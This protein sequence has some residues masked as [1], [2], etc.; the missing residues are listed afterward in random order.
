[1]KIMTKIN[2]D[3]IRFNYQKEEEFKQ[4][5]E[6]LQKKYFLIFM[7]WR[8]SLLIFTPIMNFGLKILKRPK[9]PKSPVE[10]RRLYKIYEMINR[11]SDPLNK[12][13]IS[14]L[15]LISCFGVIQVLKNYMSVSV[16]ELFTDKFLSSK[17]QNERHTV[18]TF[19]V[20]DYS[21]LLQSYP[22]SK[23]ISILNDHQPASVPY[24]L[25][26]QN[27]LNRLTFGFISLNPIKFADSNRM[28]NVFEK[29]KKHIFYL[30]YL[31]SNIFDSIPH[32]LEAITPSDPMIFPLLKIFKNS[33][34]IYQFPINRLFK[35]KKSK[36]SQKINPWN[37]LKKYYRK[38]P[39]LHQVTQNTPYTIPFEEFDEADF[40]DF[41]MDPYLDVNID[42][43]TYTDMDLD[44][45]LFLYEKINALDENVTNARNTSASAES[46]N[47]RIVATPEMFPEAT[48]DMVKQS[49]DRTFKSLLKS[50]RINFKK[51]YIK[52]KRMHDP[53]N[54]TE[55]LRKKVNKARN[56]AQIEGKIQKAIKDR[57]T[58]RYQIKFEKEY[59]KLYKE[60]ITDKKNRVINA[61]NSQLKIEKE[62]EKKKKL[63][64]PPIFHFLFKKNW[65]YKQEKQKNIRIP[66]LEVQTIIK[67]QFDKDF[68]HQNLFLYR[69]IFKY[70]KRHYYN[71]IIRPRLCS[72]YIYP[73]IKKRRGRVRIATKVKNIRSD[74]PRGYRQKV[75][76]RLLKTF[77]YTESE[78]NL[79]CLL[80]NIQESGKLTYPKK[81]KRFQTYKDSKISFVV[82]IGH[83]TRFF[84]AN[85]FN[86]KYRS[87][88]KSYEDLNPSSW[89]IISK[90][91]FYILI[92][93]VWQR[94]Y[95][96]RA[97][98]F[99]TAFVD[100]A[101][102]FGVI[103]DI[104]FLKE[105]L[106]LETKKKS[107]R[108]IRTVQKRYKDVVGMDSATLYL[109]KYLWY[110]RS[111]KY[112]FSN[113]L[114]K[115][116][117]KNKFMS[118]LEPVLLTGPPGTG[119]TI[120]VQAFAGEVGV[121][122][123]LQSGGVLKNFKNRGRGAKSIR[124]LFN[125]AR[126]KAPCIIFIDE[127]DSIGARRPGV[128]LNTEGWRDTI[129][130][131]TN[132]EKTPVSLDD[133]K[134]FFPESEYMDID[135]LDIKL[136]EAEE[137]HF[138]E[139][140]VDAKERREKRID[141]L[142]EIELK[143][144]RHGEQLSML[145]QLL[146]E[147]DG[148]DPLKDI[149]V[150]GATNRPF[151]LDPALVR[152]GRFSKV[153]K[154]QLPGSEK[155]IQ[156]LKL[157]TQSI[158]TINISKSGSYSWHYFA[159]RLEGLTAADIATIINESAL[160]ATI[161]NQAHS[162]DSI[163]TGMERVIS[164]RLA[165]GY[166]R[167]LRQIILSIR[168]RWF[169]NNFF[170]KYYRLKSHQKKILKI[171]KTPI[172]TNIHSI[173]EF[174]F[175]THWKKIAY[176]NAGQ[177][178]VQILL[179]NHPSSVYFNLQKRIK[180]FRY[181][182]LH[183]LVL[184]FMDHIRYR[185]DL[186]SRLIGLLAGKAAEYLS[187]SA[188]I[189]EKVQNI[190]VPM[191]NDL[192]DIGSSELTG[193]N[194]L[195][196][197]MVD[198]WYFYGHLLCIFQ[199]HSLLRALNVYEYEPDEVTF[200]NAIFDEKSVEIKE[201]NRLIAGDQ[202]KSFTTWWVKQIMEEEAFFDR[203]FM[204]WYRIYL[205]EP[206]EDER[207]IEWCPPEEHYNAVDI[208]GVLSILY[209]EKVL[210]LM[211]DHL[212]YSLLLNSLNIG[213][214]ILDRHRE[215]LDY[216]VDFVLR[217]ERVREPQIKILI[218]P[219]LKTI[220]IFKKEMFRFKSL[221]DEDDEVTLSRDWGEFSR[222]KYSRTLSLDQIKECD[223]AKNQPDQEMIDRFSKLKLEDSLLKY[224]SG[225]GPDP[226]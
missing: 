41:M 201:K 114:Q 3:K 25:Y 80:G 74:L 27:L 175:T 19:Q 131:L 225:F 147:L 168:H 26:N 36:K 6:S 217:Y 220:K 102:F 99:V 120:L 208:K 15:I 87:F 94:V 62:K 189:H 196:F 1:M 141:V 123:F 177:A 142:Q 108:T 104:D 18:K 182:P 187:I 133:L 124:A 58:S 83:L 95:Q 79:V 38:N 82:K 160:I 7:I 211:Y 190:V 125:R 117:G 154:L 164:Y 149:L 111:K 52:D 81:Q 184:N 153:F 72:G 162:V 183:G 173:K 98:E 224:L 158:G 107:Y 163:E 34:D 113:I 51:G 75:I 204:K 139:T 84:L 169:L 16:F 167:D 136:R 144:I 212:H 64:I 65:L 85:L 152:S 68:S 150:F 134:T 5:N 215:L 203:V 12:P 35:N 57:Y 226:E 221:I 213:Y 115:L 166:K 10:E 20:V 59:K 103:E 179:P 137:V 216:L 48:L 14:M 66:D 178:I 174:V 151:I 22:L 170:I 91:G 176:Y 186:E 128:S 161:K 194:L 77:R 156:L 76:H 28:Y 21:Y 209:W 31:N 39:I 195:S 86:I 11:T 78:N 97:E 56:R 110:L 43:E 159:Q 118:T 8:N 105:D 157:Y 210:T 198:K 191:P 37:Y 46:R 49:N 92:F 122:V 29:N 4:A 9:K 148:L 55:A 106:G 155:R 50:F 223:L 193:A 180:N 207:N 40:E 23:K 89:L 199:H 101:D 171:K 121:P 33:D 70:L 42:L 61:L 188:G 132:L 126:Q 45:L 100:L 200:F 140:L 135:E 2:L 109:S 71:S 88:R 30:Q 206:G 96:K 219:F 116:L 44:E 192:S 67:M 127:V 205:P 202:R 60:L 218:K 32:K 13:F 47:L 146:I 143:R 214:S 119:K 63:T 24:P 69:N 172:F 112:F 130:K 90:F 138:G 145:T 93:L 185:S 197:I 53:L 181:G 129:E 73:D 165:N 222:R 54:L 17:I